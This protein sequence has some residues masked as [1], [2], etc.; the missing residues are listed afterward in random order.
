MGQIFKIDKKGLKRG[1]LVENIIFL[2]GGK[3]V[4]EQEKKKKKR[5]LSFSLQSTEFRRSEFVEPK[6]KVH[7]LDEDYACVPKTRDFSKNSSE[8]FEKSKVSGL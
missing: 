7:L 4:R 5:N 2:L 6:T 3:N 8:E 1:F